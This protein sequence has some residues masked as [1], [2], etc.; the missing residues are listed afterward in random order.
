MKP[1]LDW[2]DSHRVL[3][4]LGPG[5][6]G[7]T[8][9][10][11]AL[12]LY[13][14]RH[15]R[16]TLCLT[17]DP[18]RRLAESLGV[19]ND[20]AGEADGMIEVPVRENLWA[21]MV[22]ARSA[23]DVATR[24]HLGPAASADFEENRIFGYLRNTLAG[25]H[26]FACM[27]VLL[28]LVERGVWDTIIL[29]TP[30]SQH[31][32][33]FLEAPRRIEEAVTSPVLNLFVDAGGRGLPGRGL[34]GIG[35]GMTMRVIG[36]LIGQGLVEEVAEFLLLGGDML[37]GFHARSLRMREF[38][39]EADLGFAVVTSPE[40]VPEC[41]R[42]HAMLGDMG[43]EN[44]FFV[45]NRVLTYA[46]GATDGIT[47]EALSPQPEQRENRDDGAATPIA[48]HL[49]S[50]IEENFA[51]TRKLSEAHLITLRGLMLKVGTD[52]TLYAIPQMAE[53]VFDLPALERLLESMIHVDVQRPS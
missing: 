29:D 49:A 12:G 28:D 25:F 48:P 22:D 50:K 23:V 7:K 13:A 39:H 14:A 41:I 10:T 6:V 19:E 20:E 32:R 4:C 36:R 24:R 43:F 27:D 8:T 53:D 47:F 11:S 21:M 16:R 18:A 45:A 30:P 3:V 46:G 1:L 44:E 26:E 38:L 33:D 9:V 15:G 5:G 17:I 40:T 37:K 34:V 35:T 31:A 52:H 51:N 2:I 42:L